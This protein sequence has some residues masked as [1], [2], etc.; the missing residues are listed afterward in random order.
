MKMSIQV[1]YGTWLGVLRASQ[2]ALQD[3]LS[4]LGAADNPWTNRSG[5]ISQL[6]EG[7]IPLLLLTSP[8]PFLPPSCQ[9]FRQQ[10]QNVSAVFASQHHIM[11]HSDTCRWNHFSTIWICFIGFGYW[12]IGTAMGGWVVG[13]HYCWGSGQVGP[14]CCG[15]WVQGVS[16]VSVLCRD[17]VYTVWEGGGSDNCSG[18]VSA[19]V[20]LGLP[21]LQLSTG[22]LVSR[23]SELDGKALPTVMLGLLPQ[24]AWP[25]VRMVGLCLRHCGG[26]TAES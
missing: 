16:I 11:D 5:L 6:H 1:P 7:S 19:A 13:L 15:W 24:K 23:G 2:C 4:A 14:Y 25:L 17:P 20:V 12:Q 3:P 10:T 8:S 26:C 22:H 9:S 18:R 21:V